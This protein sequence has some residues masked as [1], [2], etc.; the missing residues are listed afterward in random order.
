ML[1]LSGRIR[2]CN[3]RSRLDQSKLPLAKKPSTLSGSQRDAV[4][5]LDVG[6]QS[7]SVPQITAHAEIGWSLSQCRLNLCHLLHIQPARAPRTRSLL[8][9]GQTFLLEAAHP[10]FNGSRSVTQQFGNTAAVHSLRDKQYA[11]QAVVIAGFRIS[12]NLILQTKNDYRRIRNRQRF[13]AYMK[14]YSTNIRNY[15]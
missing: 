8:Q 2:S 10:I 15:L 13:H 12:S 14:A 5:P 4:C 11:V 1:S 9:P 7:L 6:C 3:Q